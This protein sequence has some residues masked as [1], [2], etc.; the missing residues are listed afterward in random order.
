MSS[1]K[2][3]F[4]KSYRTG[5]FATVSAAVIGMMMP[6]AGADEMEMSEYDP[7]YLAPTLMEDGSP[8]ARPGMDQLDDAYGCFEEQLLAGYGHSK[9]VLARI[10]GDWERDSY[11]P[12]MY[13]DVGERY[14]V[15]Y[16]NDR[17]TGDEET[18]WLDRGLPVGATLA[19][20]GFS[21]NDE[22][23][24]IAEPLM[25]Y[26]KMT[27]GY[28]FGRGNWRQT[29]I[30]PNG[31]LMGVTKGPGEDTL[32][33][34]SDCLARSADRMY[35]A[36]MND[37]IMPADA[38]EPST[39]M[40]TE[41]TGGAVL[42]PG[43]NLTPPGGGATLDPLA[44]LDPTGDAAP[45]QTFDPNAT[46]DPNVTSDPL[47]PLDPLQPL[48]PNAPLDPLAPLEP[49][50][51]SEAPVSTLEDDGLPAL[52][53]LDEP[54]ATL[55]NL[56]EVEDVV[57]ETETSLSE[58]LSTGTDAFNETVE[59]TLSDLGQAVEE[60]VDELADPTGLGAVGDV[61]DAPGVTPEV[62]LEL[63]DAMDPLLIVPPVFFEPPPYLEMPEDGT[64]A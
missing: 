36:L 59:E 13:D 32:T 52:S 64:G 23:M 48:D 17:A 35:L 44:P 46:V 43:G 28:I 4:R 12:F 24:L 61:A 50:E 7:C 33:A 34:C 14:L 22:G 25:I 26:E 41:G 1:T 40:G 10:F 2:P 54:L 3:G 53:P 27:Q 31:D 5:L 15:V 51:T 19:A 45:V 11:A 56:T 29:M 47:A 20:A 9:H 39:P 60:T 55:P 62:Q 8:A 30:A 21:V 42:D 16:G 49:L 37:G 58:S 63:S 38:P 57:Q 6:L 18:L